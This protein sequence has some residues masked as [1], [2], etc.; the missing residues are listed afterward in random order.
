MVAH[1]SVGGRLQRKPL[2]DCTNTVSR[3][4][5]QSSSS[6][7]SLVKFA[8]PSLTSSLKRLVDQTRLK[9]KT[10]D[11]NNSKAG[12]G[13]ASL[14]LSTSVIPVT[15]RSSADLDC[16]APTPS[17]PSKPSDVNK[18]EAGTGSAS[19]SVATSVRPVTRRVSAD[20]GFPAP[21]PS[22]PSKRKDVNKP[23]AVAGNASRPVATNVRPVTRR[24][25]ADLDFPASAP[26]RPQKSRSVEGVGVKEV[27]EPYSVYTVRRKASG[28]KRSKDESSSGAVTRLRLDLISSSG[29]K[30]NQAANI[31]KPKPSKMAPRK[32]QRTV[33]NEEDNLGQGVSKD[34]IEQQR[35]YFAEVDAFELAEEEVSSSDLD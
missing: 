5:Q 11:A 19:R 29:N 17:R 28:R 33:K 6:T 12:A 2:G 15:R 20:L 4:S 13:S 25:S 1:R 21:T 22:R 16:P 7:A 32:R 18:P 8:N 14:P 24:M 3:T 10:E 34:Y 30:T 27:A 23:E 35:A 9:E 31:N 26:T